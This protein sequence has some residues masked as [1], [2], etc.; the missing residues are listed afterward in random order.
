MLVDLNG[1]VGLVVGIANEHSIAY[2]CAKQFSA[3]GGELAITYLNDKAEPYV[4]PL[5]VTLNAG[6]IM[7]CDVEREAEVSAVFAAIKEKYGKLDFMLHSIAYAPLIDLHGS[8]VNCS[9]AGFLT[10]MDISCYSLLLMARCA[11]ALM[12]DGGSILTVSYYGGEKVVEH[13]NVMGVVKAALESATRYLAY[14]LGSSN[15]RVN[16]ISPSPIKTRAASGIDDF[17]NLVA[18]GQK[19]SPLHKLVDIDNVGNLAAFLASPAACDITGQV[20][21][22]DAGYSI[23]G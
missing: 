23:V 21:H 15:I 17:N 11:K 19:V 6:L 12:P 14:E 8:V 22:I 9:K 16:A 13:Y 4:R 7:P 18:E 20:Y 2:G 5:A 10:A 1:K 3:V